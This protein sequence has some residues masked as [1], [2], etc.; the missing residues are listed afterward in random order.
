MTATPVVTGDTH[1]NLPVANPRARTRL[2]REGTRVLQDFPVADI[3][4]HLAD[5]ASEVWLDLCR[6]TQGDFDMVDREFGLH[7]LAVEDAPA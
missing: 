4:D 6:P 7:E 5:P 2:Y 3:S 1:A